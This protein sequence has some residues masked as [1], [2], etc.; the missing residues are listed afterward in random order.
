MKH[1]ATM[2]PVDPVVGYCAS[3]GAALPAGQHAQR[4]ERFTST[5]ST[6]RVLTALVPVDVCAECA[7]LPRNV[8]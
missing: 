6:G 8:R 2:P 5:T 4:L 1:D 7:R 3:C